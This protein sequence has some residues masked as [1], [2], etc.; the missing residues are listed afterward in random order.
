MPPSADRTTKRGCPAFH[1][2]CNCL[3]GQYMDGGVYRLF[4]DVTGS[5]VAYTF[6]RREDAFEG[7]SEEDIDRATLRARRRVW[8]RETTANL[9][10]ASVS[11]P[12]PLRYSFLLAGLGAYTC[13]MLSSPL[14][15]TCLFLR[16]DWSDTLLLHIVSSSGLLSASSFRF[17]CIISALDV[18]RATGLSPPTPS[19]R[20]SDSVEYFVHSSCFRVHS[21]VP[22]R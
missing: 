16:L 6:V 22:S 10:A 3:L 11:P 15:P 18:L 12:F 8:L 21:R 14:R 17:L 4:V 20:S 19:D 9:I 13:F 5:D 1:T 2:I 7:I